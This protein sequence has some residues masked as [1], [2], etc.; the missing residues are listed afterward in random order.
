MAL[1][2]GMV[3]VAAGRARPA[4]DAGPVGDV[5]TEAVDEQVLAGWLAGVLSICADGSGRR[6]P[7]TLQWL[8][9][10]TLEILLD[11]VNATLACGHS[12]VDEDEDG[13]PRTAP[14]DSTRSSP[15]TRW[16]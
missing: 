13:S 5:G 10:L 2:A 6:H 16:G 7:Q 3:H 4:G 11:K 12:T 14:S 15:P 8:V 9:L 1:G